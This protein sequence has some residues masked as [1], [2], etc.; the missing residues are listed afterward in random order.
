MAWTQALG[1]RTH[2]HCI[3][4]YVSPQI[5]G[6][7][8]R[9]ASSKA[10]DAATFDDEVVFH[11]G[12][13]DIE[14]LDADGDNKDDTQHQDTEGGEGDS[15]ATGTALVSAQSRFK[16]ETRKAQAV[17]AFTRH[18]S[19]LASILAG[20]RSRLAQLARKV[21]L[22][23]MPSTVSLR[24]AALTAPPRDAS[25]PPEG[26][27]AAAAMGYAYVLTRLAG[28]LKQ[29]KACATEFDPPLAPAVYSGLCDH[30]LDLKARWTRS[31]DDPRPIE[32]PL[33]VPS[34]G[35]GG[36]EDKAAA[37]LHRCVGGRD[38]CT[39]VFRG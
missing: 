14:D 37:S 1:S 21:S 7:V 8:R 30:V 4:P 11:H 6:V 15:T 23:S 12:A 39:F 2:T 19:G 16:R 5:H 38:L 20:A 25:T 10:V 17:A 35:S 22:Q 18:P 31:S 9:W 13:D 33:P 36:V 27:A 26:S 34:S 24:S 28:L 29:G 32:A 3:P